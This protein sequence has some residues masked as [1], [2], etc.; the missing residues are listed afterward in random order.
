MMNHAIQHSSRSSRPP[1]AYALAF[2]A[3]ALAAVLL[4]GCSEPLAPM[5]PE[6]D[7]DANMPLINQT[8]T[9][10]DLLD[11]DEMLRITQNGDKVLVVTQRQPLR[12]FSLADHLRIDDQQ[13][14][15][16]E[17]LDVLRF[18]IP[19][20][21]DQALDIFTLFPTMP[22]GSQTV[23]SMRNELG[24]GVDIDARS[25]FEEMTFEKGTLILRF[26]NKA[27]V[28][29]RLEQIRLLNSGGGTIATSTYS[30][31]VQPGNTVTLPN[32]SLA[33][34][35]LSSR[36]RLG[37]DISTPGSGGST[38]DINS[39]Q[40]LGIKGEISGSEILS[41]KGYVP[42]QEVTVTNSLDL[43]GSSG[44][45]IK[46]GVIR[47]GTLSFSIANHFNLAADV[48]VTLR[49]ATIN[50]QPISAAANVAAKGSKTI[51]IDLAGASLALQNE[52]T[53][54]Y[55]AKVVTE[56][57]TNKTV[58]VKRSDSV[59]VT[60]NVR[61]VT[62]AEMTGRLS[63][64]TLRIRKMERSDFG[65]DKSIAG[66]IKLSEASMWATL[67]NQ[68]QLPVGIVEASVLGKRVGGASSS[69]GV[70]P[71]GIAGNSQTVLHFDDGQ[72]V[73]FLNSFTPE[74]P[75][76]LGLEGTFTLNPDGQYGSASAADSVTGDLFLEF[77]LRFT[78]VS[79]SVTDTVEMIID[80]ASRKKLAEINEGVLMFDVENHL[81]TNV[82][83][84]PEFLDGQY[85]L[86]LAPVTT[87]GSALMVRSASIGQDGFASSSVIEKMQMR[88]SGAD[89]ATIAR[90]AFIRFKISFNADQSSAS[91]FR[92]TDYVRIRGYA[93]LNV[94]TSITGK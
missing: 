39:T 25:Y 76:S 53:L 54:L 16:S 93:R 71:V 20:Y 23:P 26:T 55:D 43:A 83:I 7:V 24:L 62:L 48:A 18:D 68:A 32:I 59:C 30:G 82:T 50:G 1:V 4:G 67:N 21:L 34:L 78:Q 70:N 44:L 15:L 37:F 6:W 3:L 8:Y 22:R 47:D 79:G 92:S 60:G 77:P 56:D 42:S 51:S 57:A 63:P 12:A 52:T 81:P 64:R 94:S 80:E 9:M 40:Y 49:G 65:I 75:D 33:G 46:S 45:R 91:A 31:L 13:F 74:L 69:L 89:F 73:S 88:F 90:A 85:K 41:V 11:D 61:S 38:V 2:T 84:E 66:S 19:D 5:L 10:A 27:P 28:P 29:L 36:M 86:L 14:R 58:L 17:R 35:T 87:D 72:V